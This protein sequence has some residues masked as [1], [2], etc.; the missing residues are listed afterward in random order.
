MV[1]LGFLGKG[2]YCLVKF[3][4]FFLE[5][6]GVKSID[7]YSEIGYMMNVKILIIIMNGLRTRTIIKIKHQR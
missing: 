2:C 5:E 1:D 6:I 3:P 7:R 4:E